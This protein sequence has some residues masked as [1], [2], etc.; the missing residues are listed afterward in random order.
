[1]RGG[2]I[3]LFRLDGDDDGDDESAPEPSRHSWF[4]PPEDE[5]G[6]VVPLQLVVGR[7]EKGAVALRHAT[8]YSSGVTLDVMGLAR[9]LSDAQANR[10]FHERHLFEEDE[11]PSPAFLRIGLELPGGERVSNLGGRRHRRRLLKPDVEPA[12]P[13]FI[14]HG[15]GGGQSGGGRVSMNPG[16]W[17]WPLPK[18]GTIRVFCEWPLVEI[19]LSTAELD[20][21]ALASAAERAVPV[22]PPGLDL[23]RA[24]A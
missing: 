6:A 8:V 21:A 19:P 22:W 18:R 5:L 9:G 20:G 2:F 15:G 3:Q 1:M 11:E 17:L 4:G 16:Y 12:G 13:V 7:S 14:E 24:G 23:G 10:V